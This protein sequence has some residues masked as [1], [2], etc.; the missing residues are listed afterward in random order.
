VLQEREV[1]RV[2]DTQSVKVDVRVLAATNQP[3][4][5]RISEG[6]F[7]E[8]LYYRISVIPVELPSL[9]ERIEDIPEL[10][11]HFLL[12]RQS[13]TNDI[14]KITNEAMEVLMNHT[15]PGN[16]RELENAIERAVAL[17]D[18]NVI[19]VKDLPPRVIE[20]VQK[21]E[22]K[23][24]FVPESHPRSAKVPSVDA[25]EKA[26]PEPTA[27]PSK[28]ATAP[29]PQPPR[30]AQAIPT[31]PSRNLNDFLQEQ[32][33]AYIRSVLD[34]VGGDKKEAARLLG[35]SIATLYRKLGEQPSA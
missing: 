8:D 18:N 1:R 21:G 13:A 28:P 10:V 29:A 3:L 35:I 23:Q 25:E 26:R 6:A 31:G 12:H 16:V 30:A 17:C 22:L 7:R 9:R 33:S 15:W 19:E 4:Q 34:K 24:R 5:K 27:A 2:G 20:S 14:P 11:H 32:E